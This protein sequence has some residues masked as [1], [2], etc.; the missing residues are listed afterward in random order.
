MLP[1]DCIAPDRALFQ[2]EPQIRASFVVQF[3]PLPLFDL[4]LSCRLMADFR[5]NLMCYNIQKH[6]LEMNYDIFEQYLPTYS[7]SI[8]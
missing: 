5:H 7:I 3:Y 6:L 2:I 1:S 8:F 4:C